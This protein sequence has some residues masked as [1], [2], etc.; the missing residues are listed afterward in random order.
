MIP[1][2][3]VVMSV[4]NEEKYLPEAIDSI[5][6]Q[7]FKDFEFI[8]IN[9]GSTDKTK[10]ILESYKDKRIRIINNE[11]NLGLAASLNIGIREA[12]GEYIAR[13]DGND[14]SLPERLERQINFLCQN[15]AI[16]LVGNWINFVDED[17]ELIKTIQYPT[18]SEEIEN[19]FLELSHTEM[20]HASM[21][22]RKQKAESIGFYREK[23]PNSEDYDFFLRF[24]EKYKMANIPEILY[25]VRVVPNSA[26]TKRRAQQIKTHDLAYK[27][28]LERKKD[29]YDTLQKGSKEEKEKILK[30]LY[31]VSWLNSRKAMA[32]AFYYKG[33]LLFYNDG[34]KER[35]KKC[36]KQSLLIYPF[37]SLSVWR[38]LAKCYLPSPV[39]RIIQKFK[40]LSTHSEKR[41]QR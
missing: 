19:A 9:D 22:V 35:V 1:K 18:D 11:K 40:R 14:I 12:R 7:T 6:S 39:V 20:C 5:L 15:S 23:F 8:I 26:S 31:K 30:D 17:R 2:V 24:V 27:L 28:Y 21:M 4:Y 32:G 29:G 10:E 34:S 13:M 16:G 41:R 3:S 33:S 37:V 38:I 25:L 36:I